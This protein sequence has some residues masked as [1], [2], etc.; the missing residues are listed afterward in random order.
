MGWNKLLFMAH[1]KYPT[2]LGLVLA[3]FGAHIG[4]LEDRIITIGSDSIN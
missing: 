1:R 2:T 4:A 3:L